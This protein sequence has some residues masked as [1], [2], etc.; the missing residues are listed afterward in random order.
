[1]Y[2][3]FEALEELTS[4]YRGAIKFINESLDEGWAE[5]DDIDAKK[6]LEGSE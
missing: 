5:K 4:F 1:M 2:Y 3:T 6:L